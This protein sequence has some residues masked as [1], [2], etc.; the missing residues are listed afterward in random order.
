MRR[1]RSPIWTETYAPP[2][3]AGDETCRLLP[4]TAPRRL[5]GLEQLR[6]GYMEIALKAL[7]SGDGLRGPRIRSVTAAHDQNEFAGR[8]VE[9]AKVLGCRR[10]ML[11]VRWLF[12]LEVRQ[13]P[14]KRSQRHLQIR[15]V[16][17]DASFIIGLRRRWLSAPLHHPSDV[18]VQ[19]AA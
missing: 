9:L 18:L 8:Q 16:R 1:P 19:L 6:P 2:A 5:P 12:R 11:W 10:D 13:F 7:Q 15:R 17:P 14:G 3:E 4:L